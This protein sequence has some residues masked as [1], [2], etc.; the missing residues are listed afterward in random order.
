MSQYEVSE[1]IAHRAPMILID[2]LVNFD[3]NSAHCQVH[4]T[5]N[6]QFLKSEAYVPSY[7]GIEYMAQS[8][9]AL[10]GARA[11]SKG[12][13]VDIG[14]LLGS[15]KYKSSLSQ[16]L[17]GDTLDVYVTE[18]HQEESGLGVFDCQIVKGGEQIATA[19]VNAFQPKDPKS[20]IEES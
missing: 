15:R 14:F 16:F 20:F 19:K 9:A 17:V 6:S 7:V 12:E 3:E 5:K 1:V 11:L 18:L 4:I 8:V 10:A 2:K 13:C